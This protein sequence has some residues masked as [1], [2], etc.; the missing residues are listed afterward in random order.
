M[1]RGNTRTRQLVHLSS[2]SRGVWSVLPVRAL[3]LLGRSLTVS[4]LVPCWVGLR[5]SGSGRGPHADGLRRGQPALPP[6]SVAASALLLGRLGQPW[7][8]GPLTPA[9]AVCIS[10]SPRCTETEASVQPLI[11]RGV[12]P[13]VSLKPVLLWLVGPSES[14]RPSRLSLRLVVQASGSERSSECV[15][16]VCVLYACVCVCVFWFAVAQGGVEESTPSFRN[17]SSRRTMV[18]RRHRQAQT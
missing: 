8:G 13:C 3:T 9:S 12:G 14:Y 7:P 2:R 18:C 11:G 17:C 15:S 10:G 6:A 1:G 5:A 16:C 4:L